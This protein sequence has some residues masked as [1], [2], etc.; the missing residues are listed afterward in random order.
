MKTLLR[1]GLAMAPL[2]L[3]ATTLCGAERLICC[4]AQE[5]F[6]LPAE[7]ENATEKDRSWRWTAADSPE[8][9]KS[10]HDK[11]RT[12]DEC[13][14][15]GPYLLITSSSDGVALIRRDDK[16]CVFLTLARNAHSACLLPGKR[17]VVAASFGGDALLVY[18]QNRGGADAAPLFRLP[19]LGAHGAWWDAAN[20]RLYALGEKELLRLRLEETKGDT[21]LP[22]ESRWELPTAGG[23]DLSPSRDGKHLLITTNTHVYRFQKANGAFLPYEPLPDAKGVKSIDEHP[24]LDV[25][26]YHQA[27]A[28]NWWSDRIRFIPTRTMH[29]P[30][31]R[32]YKVRWDVDR[33]LPD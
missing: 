30:D 17:I 21:S 7:G 11:F 19:L 3:L 8:I 1:G 27:A 18:D 29:V 12:T 31:H 4:G 25:T 32:L 2:I 13:K 23:H 24:R 33:G 16:A 20:Q 5:V 26:V 15:F 22:V 28:P 9:P 6:I 14:P 10:L